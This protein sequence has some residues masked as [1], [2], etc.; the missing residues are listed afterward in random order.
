MASKPPYTVRY[1]PI[2]GAQI[3]AALLYWQVNIPQPSLVTMRNR[4]AVAGQPERR[5]RL[6]DSRR[7]GRVIL[8]MLFIVE[9][10]LR[11]FLVWRPNDLRN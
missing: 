4:S 3:D 11:A 6:I 5:P 1:A 2:A 10:A 7:W 9:V 8:G